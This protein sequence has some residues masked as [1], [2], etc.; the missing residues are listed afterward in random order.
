MEG[1]GLGGGKEEVAG[2]GREERCYREGRGGAAR[3]TR[4]ESPAF[5]LYGADLL[6]SQ[7]G[8]LGSLRRLG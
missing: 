5:T 6:S 3:Q 4:W 1:V 2:M 8:S 7:L